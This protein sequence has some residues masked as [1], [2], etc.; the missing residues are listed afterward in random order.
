MSDDL[1]EGAFPAS[2]ETPGQAESRS[3]Y[4]LFRE[5]GEAGCSWWQEYQALRMKGWT[6]RKAAFIA[7][8]IVPSERRKP[9]TL[10]R[11]AREVLGLRSARTIRK[12]REKEPQIDREIEQFRLAVLISEVPDVLNAWVSVA[13]MIDPRA[14][15]DRITLLEA[16]RVVERQAGVLSLKGTVGPL[17]VDLE[18]EYQHDLREMADLVDEDDDDEEEAD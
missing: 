9:E 14:H 8:S 1:E 6:W 2:E 10:D 7:W 5:V 4:A 13:K 18:A 17:E 3:A 16:L 11:L 12:W 15:K